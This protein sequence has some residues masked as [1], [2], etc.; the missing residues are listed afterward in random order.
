MFYNDVGFLDELLSSSSV[1]SLFTDT[2]TLVTAGVIHSEIFDWKTEFLDTFPVASLESFPL[3]SGFTGLEDAPAVI[4][5]GL[6]LSDNISPNTSTTNT[7]TA[8]R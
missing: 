5:C 6:L 1:N 7:C 3:Y 8:A 2:F 4:S